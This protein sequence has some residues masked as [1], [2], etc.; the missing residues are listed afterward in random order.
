MNQGCASACQT[1]FTYWV[2]TTA[3]NCQNVKIKSLRTTCPHICGVLSCLSI[4]LGSQGM[5][6]SSAFFQAL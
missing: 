2:L 3:C 1:I 4:H 5:V 6:E